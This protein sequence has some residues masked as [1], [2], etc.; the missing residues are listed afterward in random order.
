[1]FATFVNN[2]TYL[3]SLSIEQFQAIFPVQHNFLHPN[4]GN[5]QAFLQFRRGQDYN[6]GNL[7]YPASI[8]GIPLLH[9]V[10]SSFIPFIFMAVAN[11]LI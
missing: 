6:A 5:L 11:C 9:T 3:S 2:S 4:T 8:P 1:M 10:K 7:N